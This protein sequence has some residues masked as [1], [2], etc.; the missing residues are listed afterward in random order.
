VPDPIKP[1]VFSDLL[2][3]NPD[4]AELVSCFAD[5]LPE[6]L[7]EMEQAISDGDLDRLARLAHQLKGAGGGHGYQA[8]TERAAALEASAR[9]GARSRLHDL[10]MELADLVTRIQAGVPKH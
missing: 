5:G 6:R 1:P 7:D 4:L 2:E 10:M 8:L 3:E 9:L